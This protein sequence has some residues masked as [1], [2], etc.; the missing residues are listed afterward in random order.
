MQTLFFKAD[1]QKEDH[2]NA[3]IY[4]LDTYMRDGMGINA[5]MRD[6]LKEPM[7]EGLTNHQESFVLL[8]KEGENYLGLATCFYG[9]STFSA[10][11]L[12]NIHDLIVLPK[13]RNK[14]I[15]RQL[16]REV[17]LIGREKNCCKVTLEVRSDNENAKAL[18]K[19]EG[20]KDSEPP[21][22]FWSKRLA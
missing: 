13:H 10:Q 8:A 14:G 7:L 18:Y 9:F 19:S 11:P 5:P 22:H 3:V 6:E 17:A 16:L 4:L 1:L 21:M 12:M 15:G 2:R 20:F